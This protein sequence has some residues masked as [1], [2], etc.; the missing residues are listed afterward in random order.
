MDNGA[1]WT[2]IETFLRFNNKE[3]EK[4]ASQEVEHSLQH[5]PPSVLF[6]PHIYPARHE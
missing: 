6:G 2:N 5:Q 4:E 3:N 1:Y